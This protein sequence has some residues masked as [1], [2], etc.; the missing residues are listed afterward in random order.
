M[1]RC[2]SGLISRKISFRSE[3]KG[4]EVFSWAHGVSEV[5]VGI[6]KMNVVPS[7]ISTRRRCR[8]GGP[9]LLRELDVG[10][11]DVAPP[12]PLPLRGLGR[13]RPYHVED[14]LYGLAGDPE[15]PEGAEPRTHHVEM[16]VREAGD[17]GS[18]PEIDDLRLL[19]D[20]PR[21]ILVPP[22]DH[23]PVSLHRHRLGHGVIRVDG[24]DLP[25]PENQISAQY[26][27]YHQMNDP[28]KVLDDGS[29]RVARLCFCSLQ[30]AVTVV[31]GSPPSITNY[32]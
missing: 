9:P 25:V 10:E 24:H 19:S 2:S 4:Y 28:T 3:E 15:L 32:T 21:D 26:F 7:P 23:Y 8:H 14:V 27:R 29:V 11:P 20:E 31:A 17:D 22:Y 1:G 18:P 13:L 5:S 30:G 6:S 16:G 12:E